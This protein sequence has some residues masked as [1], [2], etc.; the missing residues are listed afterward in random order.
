MTEEELKLY[1]IIADW[2]D[3]PFW[4]TADEDACIVYL[5]QRVVA[6]KNGEEY[7]NIPDPWNL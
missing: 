4:A 1:D 2:L 5:V 6:W 7:Q 3:D